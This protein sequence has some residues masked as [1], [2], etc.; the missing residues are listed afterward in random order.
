MTTWRFPAAGLTLALLAGACAGNDTDAQ[1]DTGFDVVD[2]DADRP[3]ASDTSG[4]A[5]EPGTGQ[6]GD[7]CD[8][9][10]ACA[11]LLCVTLGQGINE[12]FCTSRCESAST[13]PEGNW[14]CLAL[15]TNLGEVVQVCAPPDLCLDRDGDGYG[16]GPG[17]LGRDC[18][19]N[20]PTVYPG[21]DEFCNGI[22]NDCDGIPDNRPVDAG[23]ACATGEPGVCGVGRSVCTNATLEC[24]QTIFPG[25]LQ[26]V[27]DGLDNDCDG[28]VDELP[29]EDGNNNFVRGTGLPCASPGTTCPNSVTICDPSQGIICAGGDAPIE[30][31]DICNGVDDNCSGQIDDDVDGLGELCFDGQGA[32]R[33]FGVTVCDPADEL[34][35]PICGVTAN[36]GAASPEQCNYQDDDCDGTV[37]NGFIN[38]SGSA[39]GVYD[40]VAN[41]GSCGSNCAN[42]WPGGPAA[43]NVTPTCPVAGGVARCSF[44]CVGDWVDADGVESNGCELLPDTNAIYVSRPQRGGNDVASCGAWNS[45]C[46]TISYGIQRA[47]TAGRA[48]VRVSEGSYPEGVDLVSGISVLGGHNA[49]NWLRD[50]STNTTSIVGAIAS[51]A[52]SIGVRA[53]SIT[54]ATEVSGFTISTPNGDAGGNSIGVYI[55]DSSS[56]LTVRDN[57]VFAGQGGGG[58]T[59]AAGQ[60]GTNGA[61]GAAG[62]GGVNVSGSC[63]AGNTRAG[64]A[65]GTLTCGGQNVSGGAGA[66]GIC[67]VYGAPGAAPAPG[68][69]PAPGAAGATP[70]ARGSYSGACT[71]KPGTLANS[72]PVP[73][74]VGGTG[75]D[76]GAGTGAS[77]PAGVLDGATS[78][79]RAASG[80]A[81]GAGQNGSGGGGGGTGRG[82]EV[83]TG[84]D[85]TPGSETFTGCGAPRQVAA[86]GGGGGSGGC[87]ATGGGGGGGGGSSFAVLMVFTSAP[88]TMPVLED[89]L[90]SRSQGGQGGAGG[91]GGRGGDGGLGALGGPLNSNDTNGGCTTNGTNGG[92]GGR[93][94]HG[95]GGGGGAGGL[96]WDIMIVGAGGNDGGYSA[97]NSFVLDTSDV[98]GGAD[99]A[100]GGSL[101][102]AGTTGTT[103]QSGRL[104][105][106]N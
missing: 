41:C 16:L 43:Y 57:T 2:P 54:S 56:A 60:N 27:C 97:S 78:M 36:T 61:G 96:S 45:P 86:A 42:L 92:D 44:T 29:S 93:G 84:Y 52:D 68:Q 90:L 105:S 63:G 14:D 62:Q 77:D 95:G 1:P 3:D 85:G 5:V 26:E 66:D 28:L 46:A 23:Q 73:G 72:F 34:A 59:G 101:G 17:C 31:D 37:D 88:G 69:G 74:S 39:P 67:P 7:L 47:Q 15:Q 99:G 12:G 21:A 51:G 11:S 106:V 87:A 6:L 49:L 24:Q 58:V 50:P 48:R 91:Q 64:G 55:R 33:V 104:R 103:G 75:T 53:V 76:G 9:D 100:G 10:L 8:E 80:G 18:D 81:G 40:T 38:T 30:L 13:C 98:T 65:G 22:D 25:Q 19:D 83:C 94:G 89:N 79:W 70:Y 32:C 4:D 102:N 71:I 35:P 20:D 82:I